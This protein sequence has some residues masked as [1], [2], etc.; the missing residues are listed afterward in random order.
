VAEKGRVLKQER[1]EA[2]LIS[3]QMRNILARGM[4]RRDFLRLSGVGL[5]GAALASVLPG[6]LSSGSIASADAAATNVALGVFLPT[7]PWS[8][9][10]IDR[11]K[12][13]VGREPGFVHWFQ[14]WNEDKPEDSS[15]DP[16]YMDAAISRGGM[17]LVSWEPWRFGGGRK[18]SDYTLKKI[19]NGTYDTYIR[20]W[21]KAAAT[22]GKPFLLR[23][24]H[25]MNGDWTSWSP[26]VN[27]NTSSQFVAAWRRVHD[28]FKSEGATNARWVWSPVAHYEGATP[29]EKVYPGDDYVDWVGISGYNWGD[30]RRWSRWQSFSQIFEE[31][32]DI[33]EDL[34]NKPIIIP[35]VASAE[36][37]GDKAAWIREAFLKEIPGKFPRIRAVAWFHVDKE[38]DWR[39]NSSSDSLEAYKDV[40]V[41][42]PSYQGDLS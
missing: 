34:T 37:G 29:F 31:S 4:S 36:S 39:V 10:E 16:S 1:E 24:A 42:S 25:E 5:A 15:F 26:G 28:I 14:D 17:P 23:F 22:W 12:D 2:A 19:I 8:F 6:I 30:T 3:G 35:E 7:L 13:L 20:Q 11:F 40:A 33:V 38:N 21:A 27:K 9:K 41:D 18:Q 32:Y